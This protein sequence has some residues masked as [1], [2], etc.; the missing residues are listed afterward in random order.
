MNL[1]ISMQKKRCDALN[2][3]RVAWANGPLE[4]YCLLHASDVLSKKL[5]RT[6]TLSRNEKQRFLCLVG[7]AGLR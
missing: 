5:G 3:S 4:S 2:C 1:R 7:E 6:I